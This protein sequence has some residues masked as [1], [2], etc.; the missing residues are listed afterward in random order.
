MGKFQE[1]FDKVGILTF[2]EKKK[3][4]SA[5][6]LKTKSPR[7]V[8]KTKHML[9]PVIPLVADLK[10]E[11]DNDKSISCAADCSHFQIDVSESHVLNVPCT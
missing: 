4:M 2:K 5:F 3:K 11:E 7:K 1:L 10:S 9:Q 8:D 6:F